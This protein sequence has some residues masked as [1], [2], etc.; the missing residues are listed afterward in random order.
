MGPLLVPVLGHLH[1]SHIVDQAPGSDICAATDLLR[2]CADPRNA[3]RGLS[4]IPSG[5]E[6]DKDWDSRAYNMMVVNATKVLNNHIATEINRQF[7]AYVAIGAVH[8]PHSPYNYYMDGNPV[9]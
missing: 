5:E 2:D 1:S 9:H 4:A 3:I 8:K 6:G 7:F